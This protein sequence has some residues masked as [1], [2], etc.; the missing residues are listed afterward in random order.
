MSEHHI[1]DGL[2]HEIY[3]LYEGG[4]TT[5]EIRARLLARHLDG[6]LVDE[7]IY[8]VREMRQK[9]RRSR[10]MIFCG[11]GAVVL[12]SAFLITFILHNLNMDTGIA[13]YGL[14]TLG[15]T[16]LFIGMIFFFG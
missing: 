10:G 1:P 14:T 12:V 15:V 5:E 13:L 3:Q 6:V 16:L 4:H 2:T 11:I 7:M 9:R 8:T